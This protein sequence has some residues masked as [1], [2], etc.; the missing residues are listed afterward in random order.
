MAEALGL[1]IGATRMAAVVPR[2]L[3]VT[4]QPVLTPPRM[5]T[6]VVPAGPSTTQPQQAPKP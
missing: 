3:G 2:R 5:T 1:S 6:S 4:R